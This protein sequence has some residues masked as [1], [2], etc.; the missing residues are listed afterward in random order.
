[1][2]SLAD[3]RAHL[4]GEGLARQKWPESLHVAAELPRTPSGKVRKFQL[5]RQLRE[6]EIPEI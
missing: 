5:R 2:P 1:M 6:G 4:E 3:L